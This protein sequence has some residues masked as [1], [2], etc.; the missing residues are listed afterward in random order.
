M[1][2]R[3]GWSLKEEFGWFMSVAAGILAIGLIG[4]STTFLLVAHYRADAMA[5]GPPALRALGDDRAFAVTGASIGDV[6]DG[7]SLH[8]LVDA[9]KVEAPDLPWARMLVRRNVR[10]APVTIQS[11]FFPAGSMN[12]ASAICARM[13]PSR[14]D[15][16]PC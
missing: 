6:P 4:Y 5:G 2:R 7:A 15:A 8:A 11:I 13:L 16:R 14:P 9:L 10:A 12:E 1:K 3:L